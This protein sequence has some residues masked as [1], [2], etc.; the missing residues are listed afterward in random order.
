MYFIMDFLNILTV[1]SMYTVAFD[2]FYIIQEVWPVD[3]NFLTK[4]V[5]FRLSQGY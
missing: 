4:L 1:Y 5:L 3:R 2:S